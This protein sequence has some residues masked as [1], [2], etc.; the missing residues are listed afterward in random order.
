MSDAVAGALAVVPAQ[1]LAYSVPD[2]CAAVG[3]S[4]AHA[5]RMVRKGLLRVVRLGSRTVVPVAE[6]ERLLAPTL[7]A[8][9]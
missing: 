7:E 2:F 4:R 9:Q 6:V 1:R 5:Y 8:Q 3:I